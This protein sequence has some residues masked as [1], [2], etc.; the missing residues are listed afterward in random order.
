MTTRQVNTFYAILWIVFA[1][2]VA[3]LSLCGVK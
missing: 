2:A 1:T 3:T